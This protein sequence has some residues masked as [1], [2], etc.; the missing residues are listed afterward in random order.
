MSMLPRRPGTVIEIR[1]LQPNSLHITPERGVIIHSA[2]TWCLAYFPGDPHQPAD[3]SDPATIRL[4]GID[5]L[6]TQII[7][8]HDLTH[9]DPAWVLGTWKHLEKAGPGQLQAPHVVQVWELAA[10][11]AEHR[12]NADVAQLI[13]HEQLECWAGRALDS[14]DL[15]QLNEAIPHSSIPDAISEIVAGMDDEDTD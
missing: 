7:V 4:L 12:L 13:T 6:T 15:R 11:L 9:C 5:E 10:Q 1:H 3:P 14:D 8:F 2:M